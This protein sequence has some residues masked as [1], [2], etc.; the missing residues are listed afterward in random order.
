M[1]KKKNE[2]TERSL[3]PVL[4]EPREEAVVDGSHVTFSWNPA[5]GARDYRV[6][7]ALDASFDETILDKATGGETRL[8]V[9][10]V[11][12]SDERTYF[13]RALARGEDGTLHGEDNVESFISG[14]ATDHASHIESPDQEEEFGP[15][16]RL[17]KGAAAEA[18]AEVTGDEK[19]EEEEEAL[20]VEHEGVEAS[21]IL[22]LT[23][24]IAAA[25]ALSI[26][27]LF[28]Y[29]NITAQNTRNAAV[30]ISGYPELR[31]NRFETRRKLSEY[32]VVAGRP[33][34]YRIPIERAMDLMANEAY[35]DQDGET[36]STELPLLPLD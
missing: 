11:F 28:Q 33:D 7:V 30:G 10:D 35:R 12:P 5:E 36:Y 26:V 4:I 23:L 25:I 19:Y 16:E 17:V 9:R 13:W 27:A 29:F 15:A 22:G 6:Q 1:S 20:G 21:Q 8:E 34:R 32:A 14:T 18:A 2:S 31:E 24:A 3:V